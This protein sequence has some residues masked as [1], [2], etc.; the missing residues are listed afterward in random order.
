MVLV[1][2]FDYTRPL[3]TRTF[4]AVVNIC[5]EVQMQRRHSYVAEVQCL[6]SDP[7]R[8]LVRNCDRCTSGP[9]RDSDNQTHTAS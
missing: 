4:V 5:A 7:A 3:R 2:I 6:Q 8:S 1:S 9:R